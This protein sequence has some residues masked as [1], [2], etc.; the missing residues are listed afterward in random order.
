MIRIH[1][2]V[3]VKGACILVKTEKLEQENSTFCQNYFISCLN[4]QN[5]SLLICSK[6]LFVTLI[7]SEALATTVL[8]L[9]RR[10][11]LVRVNEYLIACSSHALFRK[12][13]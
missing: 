10:V 11:R 12:I 3:G 4:F 5:D 8:F 2:R 7:K 1:T 13:N 9:A 6:I